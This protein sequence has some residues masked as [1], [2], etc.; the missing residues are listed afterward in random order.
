LVKIRELLL[1]C[2]PMFYMKNYSRRYEVSSDL[3]ML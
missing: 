1:L 2:Q 3:F